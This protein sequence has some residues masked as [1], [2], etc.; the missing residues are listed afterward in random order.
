MKNSVVTIPNLLS[1][2]RLVLI[3]FITAT[4][5]KGFGLVAIIL[6]VVSAVTDTLDGFIARRFGQISS[7]GKIL[8]PLADK[9]TMAA[10]VFAL[11]LRHKEMWLVL[12]VLVL[13]EA[14]MLVGSYL[15]LK[16]GTRPAEAKL[17]GKLST[18]YLYLFVFIVMLTD[19]L[20]ELAQVVLFSDTVIFILSGVACVFMICAV[21]QYSKIYVGICKG[22]YNI[23]TEKFEGEV[24]K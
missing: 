2:F 15:L 13:K 6:L 18:A 20:E 1:V 22:T 23:E 9:L 19:L 11:L 3:P 16:K 21:I 4:Y 7:L 14:F 17:F 8:D 12:S 24:L 5:S 10:V